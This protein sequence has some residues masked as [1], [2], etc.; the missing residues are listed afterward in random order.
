MIYQYDA[1]IIGAGPAG[2]SA[3]HT[4]AKAGKTILL[5][6]ADPVYVGG[7]ARTVCIDNYRFDIGGHRFFT[8]SQEV[9][10]F[11]HEVLPNDFLQRPRS[12]KIFYKNRFFDYPLKPLQA[13]FRLGV[14]ESFLCVFSY[15]KARFSASAPAKNF[16]D[17]V[18][19]RFGH[20]LFKIFFENYT[21]KV[22]GMKCTE[23]SSD[24]ASQR[25]QTLSLVSS[26]F[27]QLKNSA[28]SSRHKSLIKL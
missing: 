11:W 5:I 1:V 6:E 19:Q 26:I 18:T 21:E 13:F 22:W 15:V 12:S 9:D 20:R 24:W 16:A 17:W 8:K 27:S 2:L 25:I 14:L 7:I 3:A 10:S 28:R 4:L 23:I